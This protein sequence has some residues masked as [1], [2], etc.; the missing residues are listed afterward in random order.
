MVW[1]CQEG[2]P[3][4]EAFG[5]GFKDIFI[6]PFN[7]FPI[8]S[9]AYLIIFIVTFGIGFIIWSQYVKIS[10]TR[11]FNSDI[12]EGSSKWLK[13]KEKE[14]FQKNNS[15]PYGKIEHDNNNLLLCNDM[16][17]SMDNEKVPLNKN[18]F[19]IGGTGSGKT[20][21]LIGPNIV[22]MHSSYVIN[23]PSGEI[24]DTYGTFLESHGYRIKVFNL[25][26][27]NKGNHYNPFNYIYSDKDIQILVQTIINNT[28]PPKEHS[29]DPFWPKTETLFLCAVISLLYWYG[30]AE[31]RNFSNVMDMIR[32]GTIEGDEDSSQKTGLDE[33]FNRLNPDKN[34]FCMKQYKG[35]KIAAGKTA[36]SILI[37][38][39]ARLQAFDLKE[40]QL[41]TDTD[42]ISLDRIG[43]E[44]T[45]LFIILPTADGTFN[46]LASIMYSQL[47]QRLYSYC[48]NDAKF[49][50]L[51]CDSDGNVIYTA[52]AHD[53]N[54]SSLARQ[55]MENMLER[56]RSN[57]TRIIQNQNTGLY[58]I[59]TQRNELIAFRG[60]EQEAEE[61]LNSIRKGKIISNRE[62]SHKGARLPIH[63]QIL[64][65]E[66]ARTGQQP[67][68]VDRLA[69]WRKYE[70]SIVIIVQSLTDVKKLYP[71]D[72]SNIPGN[73]DSTVFLG[74]GNDTETMEWI[75]KLLGKET[76]KIMSNTFS[77]D[78]G[79]QS[80]QL[81]GVPLYDI[82]DL[83]TLDK[84]ECIVFVR[85]YYPYK[86]RKYDSL[87][88]RSWKAAVS[89]PSY[90]FNARKAKDAVKEENHIEEVNKDTEENH[91]GNRDEQ[92]KI[93]EMENQE[94]AAKG[95]EAENGALANG[96]NPI[97]TPEVARE[98]DDATVKAVLTEKD[99]LNGEFLTT[100]SDDYS[101]LIY[102][103][104]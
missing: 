44:K 11:H 3:V 90:V 58:E 47:Y 20:L 9:R 53:Y 101:N 30:D 50:Q 39:M 56:I 27:M 91:G 34:S 102:T 52:R 80:I 65:D 93:N 63:V 43:D 36:K 97:G 94:A 6:N 1:V 69:T 61:L 42:D 33:L 49:S 41:L 19:V 59:R 48:E 18:L 16:Y 29:G 71:Q 4:A 72:W 104:G 51:L 88:S 73:C 54:A 2:T 26:R 96:Q 15:T 38:V 14:E 7:I 13:G 66:W 95:R 79:S 5:A 98:E 21:T 22:M 37:S 12:A 77:K 85:G 23:D 86:G 40:V 55:K 32:A 103:N 45:A 35:Y 74:I 87:N 81:K 60:K 31:S 8:P 92:N 57:K 68:F 67:N 46:F 64:A 78:G 84:K 89:M 10:A 100:N 82:A 83:R 76:R 99:I 70:M 28:S 24:L 75:V 17:L 62:Q 25:S